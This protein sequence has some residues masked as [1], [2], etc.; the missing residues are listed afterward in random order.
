MTSIL[1]LPCL[2]SIWRLGR[3][4]VVLTL[5]LELWQSDIF[6]ILMWN[7]FTICRIIQL[8]FRNRSYENVHYVYVLH[9]LFR[10]IKQHSAFSIWL[11]FWLNLPVLSRYIYYL[12]TC[13]T[14]LKQYVGQTVDEFRYRWNNYKRN[15]KKYLRGQSCFQQHIFEHFNFRF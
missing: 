14:C 1:K 13:K 3:G 9:V 7:D 10:E 6:L 12:L 5:T 15:D 8:V 11:W 4:V 2:T